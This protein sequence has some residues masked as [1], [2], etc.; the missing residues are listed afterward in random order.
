MTQK[1]YRALFFKQWSKLSK[2]CADVYHVVKWLTDGEKADLKDK[3]W[4]NKVILGENNKNDIAIGKRLLSSS[5][6]TLN[7]EYVIWVKLCSLNC[8][9]RKLFQNNDIEEQ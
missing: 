2:M 9:V 3:S 8:A 7:L 1:L 5:P 6:S 4:E